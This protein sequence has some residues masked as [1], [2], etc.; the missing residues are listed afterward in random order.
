VTP[1]TQEILTQLKA[2]LLARL[3]DREQHIRE[4]WDSG[5]GPSAL[6]LIASQRALVTAWADPF[7]EWTA[8]QAD[9][10]AVQKLLM[11]CSFSEEFS[12]HPDYQQEWAPRMPRE[13]ELPT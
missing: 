6:L 13:V 3:A 11:L 12:N 10:A 9:A 7:G 8:D 2:F 1:E 4:H 5:T